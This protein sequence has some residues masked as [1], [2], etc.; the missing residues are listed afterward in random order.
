MKALKITGFSI[1]G[2]GFVALAIWVVM[3]LWNWLVPD[4]FSGPVMSYWQTAGLV[5]LSKILLTGIS[6]GNHSKKEYN[7][8]W[9]TKFHS[10]FKSNCPD[11]EVAEEKI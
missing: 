8:D 1:L 4:L 11:A 6:P 9:K 5:V 2:I 3:S 10:K 7:K